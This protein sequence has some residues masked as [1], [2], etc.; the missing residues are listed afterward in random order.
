MPI[1]VWLSEQMWPRRRYVVH[2][3]QPVRV[4]EHLDQDAGAAWLRER[5]LALYERAKQ[6]EER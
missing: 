1:A 6:G 3:G 5:V 4:P 2:F